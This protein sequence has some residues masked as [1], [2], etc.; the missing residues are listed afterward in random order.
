REST[1]GLAGI[2]LIGHR[3]EPNH[4]LTALSLL[5]GNMFHT[6][7]SGCAMPV[8]FARRNPD[9]VAGSDFLYRTA[10]G[11]HPTDSRGDKKCLTERMRVPC[12]PRARFEA[13]PRRS[14]ARRIR[15]LNDGILPNR[16]GEA[17]RAHPARGPRSASN[18]VHIHSS[19]CRRSVLRTL[20]VAIV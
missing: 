15:R 10:P 8:L 9:G 2:L 12:C 13:H 19:R 3:L 6:V 20:L 14:N 1:R 18:D 17:R 5:H 4:M 16:S 7:L 11:L